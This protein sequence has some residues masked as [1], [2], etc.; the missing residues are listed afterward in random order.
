MSS[1]KE[2]LDAAN[3]N[4]E[5]IKQHSGNKYLR[6]LMEAAYYPDRR[7]N[8]PS[9]VP[10]YNISSLH[11]SQTAGQF[12][13]IARKVDAFYREDI[14]SLLRERAFI[15]ALESVSKA[16][17]E[18]LVAIKEQKL[19]ELYPNLTFGALRSVGYFVS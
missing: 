13:Q 8:L 11:E 2:I 10:P 16:E 7:F 19:N 4:I 12:W 5:S 9:G 15:G 3:K 17:A 1:I 6:N 14:K 18:I